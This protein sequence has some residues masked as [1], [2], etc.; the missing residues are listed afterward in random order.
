MK[1]TGRHN[2]RPHSNPRK[3][4]E[5]KSYKYPGTILA[6]FSF[7]FFLR[8]GWPGVVTYEIRWFQILFYLVP[9]FQP[10]IIWRIA[11]I[12]SYLV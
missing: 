11:A 6:V 12:V 4:R 5:K 10:N 2:P 1:T 3:F 7:F 8:L 9:A